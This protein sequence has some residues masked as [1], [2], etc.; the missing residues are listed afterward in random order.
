[1]K[2][3]GAILTAA[4][5]C[6]VIL[7]AGCVSDSDKQ[8]L[9]G[10]WVL[11]DDKR[12]TLTFANDS[13]FT[14]QAQINLYGGSFTVKGSSL[15]FG[16]NI[17]RTLMA[18][19]SAD[20][21]AEDVYL[22]DLTKVTSFALAGSELKLLDK[23]GSVLLVYNPEQ[24]G[25]PSVS[26]GKTA[27]FAGDIILPSGMSWQMVSNPVV[28]IVFFADGSYG[29]KA[30]VNTYSGTYS[31]RASETEPQGFVILSDPFWTKMAGSAVDTAAEDAFFKALPQV[32][33]Y[34]IESYPDETLLN[35]KDSDGRT[36]LS[37]TA[38]GN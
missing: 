23:E 4:V 35:L 3:I 27:D 1:M 38:A 5:V 33:S 19:D 24:T 21:E 29:G 10:T 15:S 17:Y 7:T 25:S 2:L 8:Q 22:K 20:M 16:S 31:L 14:G 34:S 26:D 36:V 9:T 12:V 11:H 37:F 6:G 13:T 18:G 30:P 28:T 32:V